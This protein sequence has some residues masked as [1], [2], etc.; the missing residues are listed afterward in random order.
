M[1]LRI[2]VSALFIVVLATVATQVNANPWRGCYR[3]GWYP[4]PVVRICAPRVVIAPP[5]VV[6]GYYGR[7]YYRPGYYGCYS[8]PYYRHRY[9]R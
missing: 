5:V 4:R 2:F 9:C 3:G 7:P 6:G 8:H 1:K